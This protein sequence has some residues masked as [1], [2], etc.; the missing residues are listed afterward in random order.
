MLTLKHL[1]DKGFKVRNPET[2]TELNLTLQ[3]AKAASLEHLDNLGAQWLL[4]AK[5][6]LIS[7]KHTGRRAL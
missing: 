2:L 5:E 1:T 3:L 4:D 6:F 7:D